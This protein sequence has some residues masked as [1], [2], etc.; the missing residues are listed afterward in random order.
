MN[1][2]PVDDGS[3]IK[4]ILK[5]DKFLIITTV[6]SIREEHNDLQNIDELQTEDNKLKSLESYCKYLKVH[7][8]NQHRYPRRI[9]YAVLQDRT[10]IMKCRP[11]IR[12]I[13]YIEQ[14]KEVTP[15]FDKIL[16]RLKKKRYV[17]SY[18]AVKH[19]P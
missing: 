4:E 16:F 12:A 13:T 14:E 3:K 7:D 19:S 6:D 10:D 15:H 2:A 1:A 9:T 17:I 18:E 8:Y 5:S 11:V